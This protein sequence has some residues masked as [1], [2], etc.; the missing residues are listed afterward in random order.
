MRLQFSFQ[1]KIKHKEDHHHN[2]SFACSIPPSFGNLLLSSSTM[3]H[4]S[5]FSIALHKFSLHKFY[6]HKNTTI[7]AVQQHS[8]LQFIAD[9]KDYSSE[10]F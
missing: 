8:L 5:S 1:Y 6:T 3:H 9:D 2:D 4:C 10:R 7:L